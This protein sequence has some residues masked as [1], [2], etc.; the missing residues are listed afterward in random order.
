MA[1]LFFCATSVEILQ[2]GPKVSDWRGLE[3]NYDL[4]SQRG[5]AQRCWS[6]NSRHADHREP[7]KTCTMVTRCTFNALFSRSCISV[8][9]WGDGWSSLSLLVGWCS[10]ES[11]RSNS[12]HVLCAR[13][14]AKICS[15]TE[16]VTFCLN[17][18]STCRP[19]EVLHKKHVIQ[20]VHHPVLEWIISIDSFSMYM[21]IQL[22]WTCLDQFSRQHSDSSSSTWTGT[23]GLKAISQVIPRDFYDDPLE[24]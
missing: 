4:G 11:G 13:V 9:C 24:P 1:N 18:V 12:A 2:R 14:S 19:M 10:L 5:I 17:K 6:Y 23:G 22:A 21:S 7:T 15:V 16:V 20:N 3:L 8:T